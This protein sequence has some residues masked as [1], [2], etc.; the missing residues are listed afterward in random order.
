MSKKLLYGILSVIFGL[1]CVVICALA[2]I[3]IIDGIQTSLKY[4]TPDN[5][6]LGIGFVL[7]LFL[8]MPTLLVT[9]FTYRKYRD[10]DIEIPWK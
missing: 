9:I 8:G 3:P 6:G 4:G 2:S 7:L 10:A 1:A 5:L